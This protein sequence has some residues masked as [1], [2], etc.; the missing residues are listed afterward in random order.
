MSRAVLA[1]LAFGA[2]GSSALYPHKMKIG[3]LLSQLVVE[4]SCLQG[5]AHLE[6]F[7]SFWLCSC[8]TRNTGEDPFFLLSFFFLFFLTRLVGIGV[9]WLLETLI[10][11]C[12]SH[13]LG[14]QPLLSLLTHAAV[15]LVMC[16]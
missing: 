13:T 16:L 14:E 11:L 9:V 10:S 5:P 6:L 4:S 15:H 7:G 2:F 1:C 3:K 12:D 8:D